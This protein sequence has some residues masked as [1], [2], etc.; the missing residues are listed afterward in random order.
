MYKLRYKNNGQLNNSRRL[1]IVIH[2]VVWVGMIYFLNTQFL[3]LEWGPMSREKETLLIPL[4]VGMIINAVLFYSNAY[5]L[6]PQ[7]LQTKQNKKYW[8]WNAYLLFGLTLIEVSFDTIY[9]FEAYIREEVPITSLTER[10]TIALELIIMFGAMNLFVNILFWAIAFLYRMP[11]DWMRNERQKQQLVQDKLTAELDFLKAQINPHFLFNGINSIYHLMEEDVEKAQKIL[12]RFSELLRYQL[13]ECKEEFIPLKKELHYIANYLEIE[14]IRKGEDAIIKID[15]PELIE[16]EGSPILKIAP[17]LFSPFL[18]NAFKY[19]SLY[20]E[21]EKNILEASLN[22]QKDRIHLF[23]K[24]TID[25][26]NQSKRKKSSSGIGLDN[27][28]RRLNILYPE[29]H[30]LSI[31]EEGGFFLVDLEINLI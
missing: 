28:R 25:L 5:W 6:I 31:R 26:M 2:L 15:L 4:I 8:K 19:L 17:L 1:K 18:E 30:Q 12:L 7:Y 23:V 24:N 11:K 14:I 27:V 9:I 16:P 22:V 10:Y 13:Y 20:T 3:D 21:K 29:K